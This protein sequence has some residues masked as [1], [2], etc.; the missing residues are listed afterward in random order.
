MNF[1]WESLQR[2]GRRESIASKS[3]FLAF[4]SLQDGSKSAFQMIKI[5]IHY[6][7]SL[8]PSLP[9]SLLLSL[10]LCPQIVANYYGI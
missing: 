8:L 9:S 10:H 2:H 5:L 6:K 3:A 7:P 4:P 1:S